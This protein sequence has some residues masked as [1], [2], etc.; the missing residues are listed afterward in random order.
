MFRS[1]KNNYLAR[2]VICI[3]TDKIFDT[4]TE[5]AKYYNVKSASHISSCCKGRQSYKTIGGYK[6]QYVD[7]YLADWWEQEMERIE[8]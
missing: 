5:G 1:G 8:F 7:D 3:T 4:V 2:K 6:W